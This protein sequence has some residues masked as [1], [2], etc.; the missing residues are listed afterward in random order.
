[1]DMDETMLESISPEMLSLLS[2]NCF[3]SVKYVLLSYH[4]MWNERI[5]PIPY[6]LYPIP[7]TRIRTVLR[8]YFSAHFST[9]SYDCSHHP[10]HDTA[11]AAG[12]GGG[13]A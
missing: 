9:S 10:T 8:Q 2:T 1:M 13:G 11:A 6:I 12:G 4:L 3:D 7:Y 5:Y